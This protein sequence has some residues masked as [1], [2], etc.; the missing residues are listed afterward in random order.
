MAKYFLKNLPNVEASSISEAVT[1]KI[2]QLNMSLITK[3]E[4]LLTTVN[5]ASVDSIP[6]TYEEVDGAEIAVSQEYI[7]STISYLPILE[8]QAG[9]IISK[10]KDSLSVSR[11]NMASVTQYYG[12][13]S[14]SGNNTFYPKII[15]YV[16]NEP[17]YDIKITDLPDNPRMSRIAIKLRKIF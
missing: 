1:K 15:R 16:N 14:V 9:S 6:D 12:K 13:I 17:V 5:Y 8:S 2:A 10:I 3:A 4:N 7:Q 11:S